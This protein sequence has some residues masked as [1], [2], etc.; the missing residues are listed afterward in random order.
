[1]AIS[2]QAQFQPSE[3]V[4]SEQRVIF[5]GKVYYIHLVKEGQTLY[6]ISRAY[7]VTE[8]DIAVANPNITLEVI[9]PGMALKIPEF[10]GKGRIDESYF[11]LTKD[12]FFYHI[13][14]AGQN[15]FQLEQY[16]GISREDIYKYNP[17]AENVIRLGDTLRIPK[18][19]LMAPARAESKQEQ[20]NLY[21]VQ[22]GETLYS[23]SKKFN[24]PI[25]SLIEVNEELRWGLRAGQIIVIPV[26]SINLG[27]ENL[28]AQADFI[29]DRNQVNCDSIKST[30]NVNSIK[31]ALLMPLFADEHLR[32]EQDTATVDSLGNKLPQK[33]RFRG[34]NFIS[35]YEGLLLAVDSIRT[36]G[37]DINLFVFDTK[38][39]TSA[40]REALNKLEFIEPDLIIGPVFNWNI[41]L[42]AKFALE[43]KTPLLLPVGRHPEV[44]SS[45]P[46]AI[47]LMPSQEDELSLCAD[48]ISH[49][50]ESNIILVHNLDSIEN[51][52]IADFKKSLFNHLTSKSAYENTI[53]KEVRVNDS[54]RHSLDQALRSDL[55]NLVIVTSDDEAYVSGVLTQL[56][57]KLEHYEIEVFGLPV[58]QTFKNLR[59]EL[60]HKLNTVVYTPFYINYGLPCTKEA[61]MKSREMLGYEPYK[62]TNSGNGFNYT[63]L[64]YESGMIFLDAIMNYN[65]EFTSCICSADIPMI[66]ATYS[67]QRKKLN[68]GI[69]NSQTQFLRYTDAYEIEV[70]PFIPSHKEIEENSKREDNDRGPKERVKHYFAP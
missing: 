66:Q 48:Y 62:K 32:N 3:V 34:R 7:G 41:E 70:L 44:L 54:L 35:F 8:Q 61:V 22:N 36:R 59:L 1:M 2:T 14:Q 55:N 17:G 45:N 5:Q 52:R 16:Y 28:A 26:S 68:G 53:Y 29:F 46:Y 20:K 12:D 63:F 31:L 50:H 6:R 58:W 56:N 19:H 47:Q 39:D 9:K 15:A 21:Q 10:S 27:K 69:A 42:V 49:K 23:L 57:G 33:P 13:V 51:T 67:F 43:K 30:S 60:I 11:G 38:A 25:A 4:K 64:G 40:V 24:V 18:P 37:V 65:H